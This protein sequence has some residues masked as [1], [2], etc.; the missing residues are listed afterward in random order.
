MKV[1]RPKNQH[2]TNSTGSRNKRN[3][4]NIYKMLAIP[5]KPKVNLEHLG[6]LFVT[7]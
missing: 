4:H 5:G 3:Y 1:W 7:Q 2:L 6:Q